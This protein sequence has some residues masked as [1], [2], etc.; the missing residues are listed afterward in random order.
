[1]TKAEIVQ[2]VYEMLGYTKKDSAR[3][4]ESVFDI[5]KENLVR[6]ESVK[7]SGFGN[8]VIREKNAR[9]GRNPQTGDEIIIDERKVLTFKSSQLLRK[10]LN[11]K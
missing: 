5:V 11:N 1:M 10:A 7:I 2:T 9:K 6:G 8:F 4:V 3:I